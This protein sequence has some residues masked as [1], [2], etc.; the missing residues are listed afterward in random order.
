LAVKVRVSPALA[1]LSAGRWGPLP[2]SRAAGVVSPLVLA[3]G[4]L[5]GPGVGFE[6]LQWG[7]LVRAPRDLAVAE[8]VPASMGHHQYVVL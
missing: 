7:H 3:S 2:A 4:G 5:P 6:G 1:G 8:G